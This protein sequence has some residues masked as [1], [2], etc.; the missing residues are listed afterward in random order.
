MAVLPFFGQLSAKF[1][2][3]R[4]KQPSFFDGGSSTLFSFFCKRIRFYLRVEPQLAQYTA[5]GG[6]VL[7]QF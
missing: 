1:K 4:M 5:L 6:L 2:L 7:P 3:I